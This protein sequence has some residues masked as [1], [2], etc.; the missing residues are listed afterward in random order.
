MKGY[1]T[2]ITYVLVWSTAKKHTHACVHTHTVEPPVFMKTH[3][4]TEV[5][6]RQGVM[7]GHPVGAGPELHEAS[8]TL[9]QYYLTPSRTIPTP[10]PRQRKGWTDTIK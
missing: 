8:P 6:D 5:N 2:I 9:R 3:T 4:N 10:C 7:T 1:Q